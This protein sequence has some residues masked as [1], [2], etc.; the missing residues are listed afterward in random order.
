M[1]TGQMIRSWTK[2]P[3][4]SGREPRLVV[5]SFCFKRRKK[6]VGGGVK[7]NQARGSTCIGVSVSKASW[8][9]VWP[10][11]AQGS[12]WLFPLIVFFWRP[13]QKHGLGP[14]KSAVGTST[15]LYEHPLYRPRCQ[16]EDNS[17]P[18][19]KQSLRA[20]TRAGNYVTV[21]V[22]PGGDDGCQLFQ[23]FF[24]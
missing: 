6:S 24:F 22:L 7:W 15:L 4:L 19:A 10:R 12:K 23:T 17:I 16:D 14:A 11:L 5:K 8:L 20:R 3:V 21:T 1:Q 13:H 2:P 18:I 9:K